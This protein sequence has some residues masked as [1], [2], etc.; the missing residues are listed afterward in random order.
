MTCTYPDILHVNILKPGFYHALPLYVLLVH[1]PERLIHLLAAR[2]QK[3]PSLLHS[4]A[5]LH[6]AII[7]FDLSC[8]VKALGI[9]TRPG[10]TVRL[11]EKARPVLDAPY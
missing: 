9:P 7:T 1:D 2:L 5:W 8:A 4:T 11:L 3:L 10:A 6:G